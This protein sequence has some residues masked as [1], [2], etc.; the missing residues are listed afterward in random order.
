[1]A[2]GDYRCPVCDSEFTKFERNQICGRD[3]HC[4]CCGYGFVWYKEADDYFTLE[5]I[6][7]IE[8]RESHKFGETID[9]FQ[10]RE[11]VEEVFLGV[12]EHYKLIQEARRLW[13][14][15]GAQPFLNMR[16]DG[17][18]VVRPFSDWMEEN[19]NYPLLVKAVRKMEREGKI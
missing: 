3:Q 14:D 2:E 11:A 1:M 10:D 9:L 18:N 8:V 13:N 6:L 17:K 12:R 16:K 19:G 5:V 4:G 7:F 15:P